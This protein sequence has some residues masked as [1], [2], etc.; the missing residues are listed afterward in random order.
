MAIAVTS[1]LL[2]AALKGTT[3][4]PAGRHRV[5]D[6]GNVYLQVT[7]KGAMSW[8]FLYTSPVTGKRR[9]AGIGPVAGTFALGVADAKKKALKLASQIADGVDPLADRKARTVAIAA[10]FAV[11]AEKH[12]AACIKGGVWK[13][14]EGEKK[15]WNGMLARNAKALMALP[16]DSIETSD[17]VATLS[18]IWPSRGA[19]VL[20]IRIRA[21]LETAKGQGHLPGRDN[22]ADKKFL[23]AHLKGKA[24]TKS[25]AAL[26]AKDAPAFLADQLAGG[27]AA[28]LG[29]AFIALTAV[30]SSEAREA[31]RSEVDFATGLWTIPAERMK[32]ACAHVVP[33]SKQALALI[34]AA[35]VE[36]NPYLFPGAGDGPLGKTAFDEVVEAKGL[37]GV[38]TVHGLRS[39]FRDYMGNLHNPLT[40]AAVYDA[41]SLEFCLA[42]VLKG[43][44]A[45]YRRQTSV[46]GRAI[47]MQVWA[48]YCDGKT[49]VV[50]MPTLKAAA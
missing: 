15:H 10:T 27:S 28:E 3:A 1:S 37:R 42:H 21:I 12:I 11:M 47:I 26:P 18:P 4:I 32:M 17:I 2:T 50:P 43:A 6:M 45:A 24:K 44:E 8:T 30:R 33:L 5:A 25:H 29:L 35:R 31:L 34:E 9:E 36:G 13:N 7:P 39:T 38:T 16:V 20:A 46:D 49:N 41:Q 22:P 14:P 19:E 48:D 23:A 40:G